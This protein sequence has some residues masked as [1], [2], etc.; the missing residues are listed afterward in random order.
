MDCSILELVESQR[1]SIIWA[2]HLSLSP[3]LDAEESNQPRWWPCLMTRKNIDV[4]SKLLSFVI[5]L[6]IGGNNIVSALS[7]LSSHKIS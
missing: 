3:A 1:E 2:P 5:V 6:L 4:F 7:L